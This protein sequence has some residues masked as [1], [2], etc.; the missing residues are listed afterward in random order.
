MSFR[1]K[2]FILTTA[3]LHILSQFLNFREKYHLIYVIPQI[4]ILITIC[5]FTIINLLLTNS[6][7]FP[8]LKIS[9]PTFLLMFLDFVLFKFVLYSFNRKRTFTL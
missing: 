9:E 3:R 1:C 6:F 4:L 7:L 2:I 8:S 5:T